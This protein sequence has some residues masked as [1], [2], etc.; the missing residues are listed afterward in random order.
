MWGAIAIILECICVAGM[1]S[2]EDDVFGVIENATGKRR[3]IRTKKGQVVVW[4]STTYHFG[5]N[6]HDF[7]GKSDSDKPRRRL[8]FYMDHCSSTGKY[9]IHDT[10]GFITTATPPYQ[11]SYEP[12]FREFS[13]IMDLAKWLGSEERDGWTWDVPEYAGNIVLAPKLNDG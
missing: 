5:C 1:V 2:L 13:N 11:E 3:I 8:F 10:D 9:A 4:T 6:H 7:N 12:E